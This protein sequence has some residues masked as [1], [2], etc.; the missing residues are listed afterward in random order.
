MIDC[1][2]YA[3]YL[4]MSDARWTK[5]FT[6]QTISAAMRD[7]WLGIVHGD[8]TTHITFHHEYPNLMRQSHPRHFVFAAINEDTQTSDP[9]LIADLGVA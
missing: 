1:D 4:V 2:C 9:S 8:W 3:P 7:P 5:D 6:G